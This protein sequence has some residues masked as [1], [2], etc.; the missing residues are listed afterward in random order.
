MDLHRHACRITKLSLS[1]LL[2]SSVWFAGRDFGLS[3]DRASHRIE[4]RRYSNVRAFP[5]DTLI[6]ECAAA[7]GLARDEFRR[8]LAKGFS[9]REIAESRGIGA[10]EL[11][12]RLLEGRLRRIELAVAD[13]LDRSRADEI[14]RSA[15]QGIDRFLSFRAT[16]CRSPFRPDLQAVAERLGMTKR[17]LLTELKDGRSLEEI[18]R[19]RNVSREELI[20]LLRDHLKPRIREWMNERQLSP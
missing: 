19:A 13:G 6:D 11:R 8:L 3:E 18:A 10:Q 2:N 4:R 1:F 14:R 5:G 12:Q 7:V 9:P 15:E 20:A 16:S 17:E